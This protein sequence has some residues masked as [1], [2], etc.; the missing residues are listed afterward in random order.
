MSICV[1]G[2]YEC[3]HRYM[4]VCT[5]LWCSLGISMI[6]TGILYCGP[7]IRPLTLYNKYFLSTNF[8]VPNIFSPFQWMFRKGLESLIPGLGHTAGKRSAWCSLHWW[9]LF[10][11]IAY[12]SYR[13]PYS[14]KNKRQK[15]NIILTALVL[16]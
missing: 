15:L 4:P 1:S 12:Q 2:A 14:Y 10:S 8:Q 11:C 7:E 13:L 6:I 3:T 5:R 9:F 16:P